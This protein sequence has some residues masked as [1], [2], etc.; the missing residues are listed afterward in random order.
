MLARAPLT[1]VRLV[2]GAVIVYLGATWLRKAVLRAA[3]R[4]PQRDEAAAFVR[5]RDR[6]RLAGAGAFA[7]AF[8]GVFAEGTEVVVIVLSLGAGRTAS[9][10]AATA[11]VL[12][13]IVLV[14][15][16]GLAVRAPLS[17]VPENLLKWIVAVV[18]LAF[19]TLWIGEGA[20]ISW[21]LGDAFVIA[22]GAAYAVASYAA[23]AALRRPAA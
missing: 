13:A 5:E 18:L 17:R 19:G 23:V 20:G 16:T 22:L 1:W 2:A 10:R 3:G 7:A 9:L 6:L 12:L 21:P 4:K 14:T 15:L 11:G 8:N